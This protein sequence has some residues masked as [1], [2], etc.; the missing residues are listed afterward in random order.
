MSSGLG[1]VS[2]AEINT[3]SFLNVGRKMKDEKRTKEREEKRRQRL[4]L[5]KMK[6]RERRE[7][8]QKGTNSI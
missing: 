4:K 3:N 8:K 2:Y 5:R 1:T 6:Q 7:M